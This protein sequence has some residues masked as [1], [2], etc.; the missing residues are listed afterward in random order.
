MP[1]GDHNI[2]IVFDPKYEA[3]FIQYQ[4]IS[5]DDFLA[6]LILGIVDMNER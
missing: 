5:I 4:N 3:P 2:T 6:P 1:L